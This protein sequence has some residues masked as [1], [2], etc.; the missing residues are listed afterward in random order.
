MT[1]RNCTLCGE[2]RDLLALFGEEGEVGSADALDRWHDDLHPGNG[3]F[4]PSAPWEDGRG[5]GSADAIEMAAFTV[6]PYEALCR[7]CHMIHR[8]GVECP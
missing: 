3:P 4:T 1:A 8:P 5:P 7:E 2:Q 6:G